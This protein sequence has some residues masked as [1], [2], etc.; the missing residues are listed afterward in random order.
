MKTLKP[1]KKK[2]SGPF[3]IVVS[4][5]RT[6]TNSICKMAE[7]CGLKPMHILQ[8]NFSKALKEYNF[9]ANTP[10]Y[11]PEFLIGILQTYQ[12][13]RFIYIERPVEEIRQ[14]MLA[15]KYKVLEKPIDITDQESILRLHDMIFLRYIIQPEYL[16]VHKS[17]VKNMANLYGVDFLTYSFDQ[18]WKPFCNFIG[19][20]VPEIELPHLNKGEKA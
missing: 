19:K 17:V 18:G 12:N 3:Y 14:S 7:I 5:P 11:S 16:K 8:Q 13:V 20:N 2:S 6:G 1:G 4:A 10:F 15:S 9:F